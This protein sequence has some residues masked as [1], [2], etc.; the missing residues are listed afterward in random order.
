MIEGLYYH[1]ATLERAMA[2]LNQ[3]IGSADDPRD[4]HSLS[5]RYAALQ[6]EMGRTLGHIDCNEA[7]IA[8][9]ERRIALSKRC[10]FRSADRTL[11]L[12]HLEDASSRLRRELGD[13]PAA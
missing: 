12:R 6:A 2:Q 1:V 5:N 4:G 11:A 8:Q 13:K 9:I 7:D 10:E 3:Q